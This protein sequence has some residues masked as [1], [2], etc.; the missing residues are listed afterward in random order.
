[1]QAVVKFFIMAHAISS[2][3]FE[4][5]CAILQVEFNF[6]MKLQ[7]DYFFIHH[8]TFTIQIS[9]MVIDSWVGLH[10]AIKAGGQV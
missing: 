2:W 8:I 4:P 9:F 6:Q 7:N 3:T 10:T 1:M 5:Q